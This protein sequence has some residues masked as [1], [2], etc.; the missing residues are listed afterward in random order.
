MIFVMIAL[1]LLM[2]RSLSVGDV[3]GA[4]T[5]G[6]VIVVLGW[7]LWGERKGHVSDLDFTVSHRESKLIAIDKQANDNVM[8]LDRLGKTNGFTREPLDA[9]PQRQMLTFN[10]LHVAF[11][12]D[13][14]FGG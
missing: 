13:M 10:L 1:G 7:V 11:A 8:H 4:L 14:S 12:S 6:F 3:Y 2:I 5:L 9:R